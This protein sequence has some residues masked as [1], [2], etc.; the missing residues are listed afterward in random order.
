M[1]AESI[2][3]DAPTLEGVPRELM[4]AM[5]YGDGWTWDALQDI[6]EQQF[7]YYQLVEGQVLMSPSPNRLHQRAVGRIF[8][9]LTTSAPREFE[10][11]VAP[12]DFVPDRDGR[13]SLQ[14]DVLVARRAEVEDKRVVVPPVLAVEVLSPSRRTF[15]LTMKREL[16]ARHGVRHHWVVDPEVPSILALELGPDGAYAEVAAVSGD[17]VFAAFEPFPVEVVPTA[18]VED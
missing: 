4:V 5:P 17:T 13:T 3:H 2:A 18:L 9:S 12:F 7:H 14:P 11:F 6:P 8:I 16:Y 15:D 10:V 1:S